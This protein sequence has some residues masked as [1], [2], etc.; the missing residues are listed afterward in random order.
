MAA[1]EAKR[2]V[3]YFTHREKELANELFEVHSLLRRHKLTV[4]EWTRIQFFNV[5]NVAFNGVIMI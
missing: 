1:S 4:G 2:D 3:F 5:K